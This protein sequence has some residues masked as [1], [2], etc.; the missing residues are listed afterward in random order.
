MPPLCCTIIPSHNQTPMHTNINRTAIRTHQA[1]SDGESRLFFVDH[2][3]INEEN[4]KRSADIQ[5]EVEKLGGTYLYWEDSFHMTKYYNRFSDITQSEFVIFGTAD[6]IFYQHWLA[7]MLQ[8][9]KKNPNLMSLHPY[10]FSPK[11]A[12]GPTY[13]HDGMKGVGVAELTQPSMHVSLFKRS[14]LFR[15]NEDLPFY[16][17]D[18]DYYRTLEKNG[19]KAGVSLAARVDHLGNLIKE[20]SDN[21][22]ITPAHFEKANEILKAKWGDK[23]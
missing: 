1:T 17:S 20:N 7:V 2:D 16:E 18:T 6:V 12:L 19:L 14:N 10:S 22:W 15:W 3:C 23:A 9:F 4:E 5:D 13:R 11:W 8:D 21:A